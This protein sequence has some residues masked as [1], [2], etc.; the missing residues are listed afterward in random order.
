MQQSLRTIS[1][2]DDYLIGAEI[3][4]GGMGVVY[5]AT[6]V[7][8]GQQVAL[9][10]LRR[11]DAHGAQ[12]LRGEIE[13]L[14]AIRH[15]G[16]VPLLDHGQ[17]EHGPWFAM[18]L[19]EQHTFGVWLD[20]TWAKSRRA[21]RCNTET[22]DERG[23]KRTQKEAGQV[24]RVNK[25]P[26]AGGKLG[27][28]LLVMQRLCAPLAY[29]HGEG[30]VHGDVKPTN[31]FVGDDLD[32]L[33]ADFGVSSYFARGFD[34]EV[35]SSE[36]PG[37]GTQAYMAPEQASGN[38]VD[39]RSDLYSLGV[40]LY[41]VVTGLRPP[42]PRWAEDAAVA[43]PSELV[44]GVSSELDALVMDLLAPDPKRRCG[45]ARD[46]A[47]RLGCLT[48]IEPNNGLP[49]PKPYAYKPSLIG[50]ERQLEAIVYPAQ[51]PS[52]RGGLVLLLGESG[53]GKSRFLLELSVRATTP[54]IC[55]ER[56]GAREAV[57]GHRRPLNAP[58]GAFGEVLRFAAE[59]TSAGSG[60]YLPGAALL[61][62]VEPRLDAHVDPKD[63]CATVSAES[64]DVQLYVALDELLKH[65]ARRRGL[66]VL[67]DDLQ[68]ADSLTLGFLDYFAQRPAEGRPLIVATCRS[69]EIPERLSST[70]AREAVRV[71]TIDRLSPTAVERMVAEML[72][73]DVA[74]TALVRR[75]IADSEGNPFVVAQSIHAALLH[76]ELVRDDRGRWELREPGCRLPA[77]PPTNELKRLVAGRFADLTEPQLAVSQT[78]A[79]FGRGCHPTPLRAAT[80]LPEAVFE[81]AVF[82]LC[83]RELLCWRHGE[84]VFTHHRVG[85]VCYEM[86]SAPRCEALH[87]RAAEALEAWRDT[88]LDAARTAE[89][90]RH[91]A[92]AKS[93][94]RACRALQGAAE[95]YERDY[96]LAEAI[97]CLDEAAEQ[98]QLLASDEGDGGFWRQELAD[99]YGRLATVERRAGRHLDAAQHFSLAIERTA[100]VEVLRCA[101]LHHQRAEVMSSL[102]K[103]DAA[104]VHLRAAE[105][106]LEREAAA[107]PS[108]QASLIDV[109]LTEAW[110]HYFRNDIR[111]LAAVV[112]RS[113]PAVEVRASALQRMSF[114][115]VRTLLA[116]RRS[117][118]RVGERVV[119]DAVDAL[120]SAES[121]GNRATIAHAT[122]QLGFVQLFSAQPERAVRTLLCAADDARRIGS[123]L[124]ETRAHTYLAVA[125][126]LR[127]QASEV[128]RHAL[129]A[130]WGAR[131][132][133]AVDYRAAALANL[134]WCASRSGNTSKA[135]GYC[136]K[137]L[138][139][140][141][142]LSLVFPL[143]WL[144]LT[145]LL[146]HFDA[147]GDVLEVNRVTRALIAQDQ[148]VLPRA[149]LVNAR[150]FLDERP[151]STV[152]RAAR[153]CLLDA[154][155]AANLL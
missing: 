18:P 41:E 131:T 92:R 128:R 8:T 75:V 79:A 99:L 55:G 106:L 94:E 4:R 73:L 29:V 97:G 114:L 136:S 12:R 24:A 34:R 46:V 32:P 7:A 118:Y 40:M 21:A 22:L 112:R 65:L 142:K 151:G 126:R 105:A 5:A 122:F 48:G 111:A 124:V 13:A 140:W 45:Y 74:P 15:P 146:E 150:L 20:N 14:E 60:E 44:D 154:C 36:R 1:Q 6:S 119:L 72:A 54:L 76:G 49:A 100:P 98:A 93:A 59:S 58:F 137:A 95:G 87:H 113:Q 117:R 3:G 135:V 129:H 155:L 39:A 17:G 26:A 10:T 63:R 56:G 77:L 88:P 89:V 27:Q 110:V 43:L 132:L 144:A 42:A 53:A 83:H 68:W 104:L 66:C 102:Q 31:I 127:G 85:E 81:S 16:I 61:T 25:P 96:A 33:L 115:H 28:A 138:A 71:L 107:E 47:V 80:H 139:H 152:E 64:L 9:K 37:A 123:R 116:L 120:Q 101:R 121:T 133:G 62:R 57:G 2:I 67:L 147:A 108:A 51:E 38:L 19:L 125:F 153:R 130:F 149:V 52:A 91:W 134:G 143:Q 86:L 84:L 69:G 103:H 70:A 50:R 23:A 90:G 78:A 11:L 35:A 145:P 109:Q 141:S 30:F 82:A 148:Q